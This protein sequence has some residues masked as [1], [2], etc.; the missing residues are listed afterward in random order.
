MGRGPA[1]RLNRDCRRV[2][3][4]SPSLAP[5]FVPLNFVTMTVTIPIEAEFLALARA[6]AARNDRTE[7]QQIA[8]WARLGSEL[9]R[10]LRPES[11]EKLRQVTAADFRAAVDAAARP[12]ASDKFR[13]ELAASPI[14]RYSSDP[15]LKGGLIQHRSDGSSVRGKLV[16]RTFVPSALGA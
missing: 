12:G 14:P 13:A 11:V 2:P 16:G 3:K 7:E 4:S 5:R 8:D 9:E 15:E 6:A 10:S 1:D